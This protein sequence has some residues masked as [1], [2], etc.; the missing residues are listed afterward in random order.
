VALWRPGKRRDGHTE[1]AEPATL[2]LYSRAIR[3]YARVYFSF[4]RGK[5]PIRFY[6]RITRC[7]NMCVCAKHIG[8]KAG[9][10]IVGLR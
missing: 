10:C 8:Y 4:V 1:F 2:M 5:N 3:E 7:L 9:G 6:I